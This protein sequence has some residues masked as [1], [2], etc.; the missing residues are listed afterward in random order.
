M[1]KK[2]GLALEIHRSVLDIAPAEWNALAGP[3]VIPFLEWEWLAALEKSGSAAPETG[4][5]PLHLILRDGA[6]LVGAAPLYLKTHS[7]GEFVFDQ[8]WAE[9]ARSMKKPYFPKLVG[10]VPATPAE[11]YRFLIA[12]G[13]DEA[14]VTDILLAAA[15]DICVKNGIPGF[16]ILFADPSWAASLAGAG[17]VPWKH[18]HYLWENRSYVNFDDYLARFTKNQRK[19]I[20]KE[21]NRSEE[22][23]IE[24]RIVAG[25]EVPEDHFRRMFDLYS[26]TNDKFVPWDARYVNEEFFSIVGKTFGRRIHFSEARERAGADGPLALAFLVRKGDRVWGRYWGS[27]EDVRDLHFTACYYAPMEWC[28]S[29]GIRFFDPGAGSPHKIRRGF[30]A[31]ADYSYHRLFDPVLDRLFRENIGM[32]NEYEQGQMDE[33]NAELP[34]KPEDERGND[35][36][37]RPQW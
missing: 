5:H 2:N 13:N 10:V 9:A 28:I 18:H 33:L 36:T 16:H 23:G 27:Y 35:S 25:N 20:R 31:V 17:F 14:L 37:G 26:R 34:L 29:E 8:F 3:E 11:G 19:N 24:V 4:W 12:E 1:G 32:V 30:R 15:E 21:K 22:Q 6:K 7:L